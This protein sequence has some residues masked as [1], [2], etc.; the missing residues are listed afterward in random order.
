MTEQPSL[1]DVPSPYRSA[2]F[3]DPETSRRAAADA[4]RS[5][6]THRTRALETLRAHHGGLTDFELAALLGVAQTSI[7]KRR[8]ELRDAGLVEDSGV[9][10]P[11]PSGSAAI[12]WRIR[13]GG[14]P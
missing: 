5:A 1:F 4:A 8:G 12:V 3:T 2:R 10:R 14:Q 6:A 13:L 11:A 9:R 7:G